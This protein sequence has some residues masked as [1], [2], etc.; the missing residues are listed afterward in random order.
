M[1]REKKVHNTNPTK[2]VKNIFTE[3]SK[4]QIVHNKFKSKRQ[5]KGIFAIVATIRNEMILCYGYPVIQF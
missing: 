4:I 1:K 2:Y 5:V 3:Y